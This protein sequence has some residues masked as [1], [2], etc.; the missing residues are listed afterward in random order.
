MARLG[1]AEG[2]AFVAPVRCRDGFSHHLNG[3]P[4]EREAAHPL[5]VWF[6]LRTGLPGAMG[7]YILNSLTLNQVGV[8]L[9]PDE[10][11]EVAVE[12]EGG[13]TEELE[14]RHATLLLTNKRFLRY[15]GAEH[16]VNVV[17]TSLA[18]VDSIE[19]NESA[20]NP[21]WVWVGLVFLVGGMLLGALALV[22]LDSPLSP[23]LM[24]FSLALIGVVFLL[25]YFNGMAGEVIVTAGRKDIRCKLRPKALKDMPIFVQRFYELKLGYHPGPA[26]VGAGAVGEEQPG[27]AV[28]A[29]AGDEA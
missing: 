15:S 7:R 8:R 27:D 17:S 23:L 11:V 1:S 4:S 21:Q 24:A 14:Q 6:S 16:K 2:R 20:K 9:L 13:L 29:G 26:P 5:C 3:L 22:L 28:S 10:R 18:D 12:L 19:V 25:T